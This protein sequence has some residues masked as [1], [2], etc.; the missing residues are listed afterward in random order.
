MEDE[1][2]A[3]GP[4]FITARQAQQ[5]HRTG[6]AALHLEAAAWKESVTFARFTALLTKCFDKLHSFDVAHVD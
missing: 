3:L 1:H 2:F 4:I 6:E 5:A